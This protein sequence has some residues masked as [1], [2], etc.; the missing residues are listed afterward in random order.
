M[1]LNVLILKLKI[2]KYY[3]IF[4]KLLQFNQLIVNKII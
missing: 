4:L 2:T 1:R 3:N